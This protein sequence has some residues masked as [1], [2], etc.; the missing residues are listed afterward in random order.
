[1]ETHRRAILRFMVG[2]TGLWA[3]QHAAAQSGKATKAAVQYQDQPKGDQT[4]DTCVQFIPGSKPDANG[5]CKVVE[6]DINPKGWCAVWVKK[7]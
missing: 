5:Q 2:V 3:A 1:M 6:G 4:C 7:P